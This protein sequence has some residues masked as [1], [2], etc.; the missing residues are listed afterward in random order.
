MPLVT[1]SVTG[2]ETLEGQRD[3]DSG[4]TPGPG[5]RVDRLSFL[6]PLRMPL[7]SADLESANNRSEL[8]KAFETIGIVESFH[9]E[10]CELCCTSPRVLKG[11]AFSSC[12][13]G[14]PVTNARRQLSLSK[15]Y[16]S[17]STVQ[18]GRSQLRHTVTVADCEF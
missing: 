18:K 7:H 8:L 11:V 12:C 6:N 10:H 14:S 13:R 15:P 3:E 1:D 9:K 4:R 5:H 16:F 17:M 2:G